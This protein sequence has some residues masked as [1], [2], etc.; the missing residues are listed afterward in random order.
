MLAAL[1]LQTEHPFT[2][3]LLG[4]TPSSSMQ[5]GRIFL[6]KREEFDCSLLAAWCREGLVASWWWRVGHRSLGV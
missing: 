5:V 6:K 4:L 1:S 3:T 2:G